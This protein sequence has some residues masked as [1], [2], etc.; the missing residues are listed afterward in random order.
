MGFSNNQRV[1]RATVKEKSVGENC[2]KKVALALSASFP[3]SALVDEGKRRSDNG[4]R[5]GGLMLENFLQRGGGFLPERVL[6]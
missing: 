6:G 1:N 3:P 5:G 4:L 2:T